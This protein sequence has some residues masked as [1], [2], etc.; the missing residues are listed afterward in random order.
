MFDSFR[1]RV[2]AARESDQLF[3]AALLPQESIAS[4]FGESSAILDSA[5]VYTTAVTIWTFLSQVLSS[6]HGCVNAVAKLIAFR[7][8]KDLSIPSSETG[9]YCI[10][11][12]KLDEDA[13]HRTLCQNGD[14]IEEAAPDEWRWL[15]HRVIAGDGSTVTMPDT[16]EN[17]KT[18]PQETKQ[19]KGCGFPLMRMVV[20]F[21]VST[22]AV[23]ELAMGKYK[24]KLS[25]E[26]SMFRQ[27]D[28]IIHTT[29]HVRSSDQ[30]QCSALA[31]Q[32]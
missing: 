20:L 13:M 26:I 30:R 25:G 4:S 15:G 5:R 9:A 8:A 18:Y 17:Q 23:L 29:T 1:S 10:A 7:A 16:P 3:F 32:L 22:G 28:K 6:D 31:D 12:D 27:I 19:K 11:R 24:G 2:A 14:A 21:A